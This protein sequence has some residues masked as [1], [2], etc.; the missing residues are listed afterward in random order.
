MLCAPI[1][2]VTTPTNTWGG[3]ITAAGHG[4]LPPPPPSFQTQ[5]GFCCRFHAT[6]PIGEIIDT[7][8]SHSTRCLRE[9]TRNSRQAQGQDTQ[10]RNPAPSLC[11][12]EA[13]GCGLGSCSRARNNQL[14]PEKKLQCNTLLVLGP[15]C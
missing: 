9:E 5:C 8:R 14:E 11:L 10:Y 4:P 3:I 12:S 6:R 13:T 2:A 7:K 1:R 15:E